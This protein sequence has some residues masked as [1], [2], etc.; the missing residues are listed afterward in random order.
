[1]FMKMTERQSEVVETLLDTIPRGDWAFAYLH[2]EFRD[3][4]G[5]LAH[6]EEGFLA[7]REPGGIDRATLPVEADAASA[8]ERMFR[9]YQEAGHGFA[10]LDLVV[11]ADGAYRFD[12]DD[13]PSLVLAGEPDA[14]RPGRLDRRMTEL[15]RER[16][17][18][19]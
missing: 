11:E 10:R 19:G 17:M 13:T 18:N 5:F 9:T 6:F 12:L 1:M 16:G 15:A 2:S 8:L 14:D 4:N 7:I 3:E